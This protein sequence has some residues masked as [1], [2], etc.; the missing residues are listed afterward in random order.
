MHESLANLCSVV[1]VQTLLGNSGIQFDLA[2]QDWLY[3]LHT[4]LIC[5]IQDIL[6]GKGGFVRGRCAGNSIQLVIQKNLTVFFNIG[7]VSVL[8]LDFDFSAVFTFSNSGSNI[9]I[10]HALHQRTGTDILFNQFF[11][12]GDVFRSDFFQNFQCLVSITSYDP[13]DSGNINTF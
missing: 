1:V 10:V 8:M 6:Y 3:I 5:K 4:Y 2:V 12:S 7:D 11:G 13:K 9:K